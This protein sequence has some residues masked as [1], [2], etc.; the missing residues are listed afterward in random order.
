[1]DPCLGM[2]T[3]DVQVCGLTASGQEITVARDPCLGCT[4]PDCP[5]PIAG[6]PQVP[7]SEQQEE[8]EG[9]P[10]C[11]L[12]C[13]SDAA[14]CADGTVLDRDPCNG[15]NFPLCANGQPPRHTPPRGDPREVSPCSPN[16]CA[17]NLLFPVCVEQT[18]QCFQPPCPQ[19]ICVEEGSSDEEWDEGGNGDEKEEGAPHPGPQV[20]T[21]DIRRCEDG[22]FVG[23]SLPDCIF[24]CRSRV[25]YEIE[26]LLP[27]PLPDS[28]LLKTG[29]VWLAESLGLATSEITWWLEQNNLGGTKLWLQIPQGDSGTT[30]QEAEDLVSSMVEAWCDA[31]EGEGSSGQETSG[32]AAAQTPRV[33]SFEV[34]QQ[35]LCSDGSY[36][37]S[38]L[39]QRSSRSE[40]GVLPIL[41]LAFGGIALGVGVAAL[42][43]FCRRMQKEGSHPS[44]EP[45]RRAVA[46]SQSEL[47]PRSQAGAAEEEMQ[48]L[49]ALPVSS[50]G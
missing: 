50:A 25:V 17:E 8:E 29:Y 9:N 3:A 6:G 47:A 45:S 7:P 23:R 26:I 48:T 22:S 49:S 38:C 44:P 34:V 18:M 30:R 15:C 33:E 40:S 39:E 12:I 1:M 28:E 21:A 2:C 19:Y 13:T 27:E 11:E 42:V 16:P 31:P 43:Y 41:L 46:A 37:P 35:G 20:C 36:S 4:F 10:Q 14:F 24:R 5:E 32:G